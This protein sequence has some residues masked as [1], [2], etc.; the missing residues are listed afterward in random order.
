[1]GS[2]FSPDPIPGARIRLALEE[3]EIAADLS[4]ARGRFAVRVERPGLAPPLRLRLGASKEGFLSWLTGTRELEVGALPFRNRDTRLVLHTRGELRGRVLEAYGD[5]P[6]RGAKVEVL[7]ESW[8]SGQRRLVPREGVVA[9]SD[10]RGWFAIEKPADPIFMD[11]QVSAPHRLPALFRTFPPR[12]PPDEIYLV[13]LPREADVPRIE[14]TVRDAEGLPMAGAILQA[15]PPARVVQAPPSLSSAVEGHFAWLAERGPQVDPLRADAEGRYSFPVWPLGPREVS[16]AQGGR[17]EAKSVEVLEPRSYTCDFRLTGGTVTFVGTV[18][19]RATGRPVSGAEVVTRGTW[20]RFLERS[21]WNTDATGTFRSGPGP[22]KAVVLQVVAMGFARWS[23]EVVPDEAAEETQ[24]VVELEEEGRLV[25]RV[26][27]RSGLGLP[28]AQVSVQQP[29]SGGLIISSART[30]EDGRFELGMLP[31]GAKLGLSVHPPEVS[32]AGK[33]LE[34][35]LEH[36]GEVRD[37]GT[38]V[39]VPK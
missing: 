27:D 34:V 2:S 17:T 21:A 15:S 8:A 38:I 4:D 33:T 35:A 30:D 12:P 22:R 31:A 19:A 6:I 32:L 14:G 7:E 10:E 29:P 20:D 13:R 39:L 3:E 37:L 36:P 16:A 26:A 1:D 25:G 28:G 9:T 18:R 11:F 5:V 24:V 23:R